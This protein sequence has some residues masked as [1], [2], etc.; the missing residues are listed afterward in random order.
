MTPEQESAERAAF[1]QKYRDTATWADAGRFSRKHGEPRE[2]ANGNVAIAWEYWKARASI[3]AAELAERDAEIAR[4]RAAVLLA[5]ETF[6]HYGDLHAAKPDMVKA[7]RN[8]GLA[9]EM[10]RAI[11]P[12][13]EQERL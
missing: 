11:N 4:L 2:Y 13:S 12:P 10:E 8:Y 9:A 5:E 3:A 7:K 6:W 1:E